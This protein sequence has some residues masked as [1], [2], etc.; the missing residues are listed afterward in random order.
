MDGEKT[1]SKRESNESCR[2][3]TWWLRRK[4]SNWYEG[5]KN[6]LGK[7]CTRK[8]NKKQKKDYREMD[9]QNKKRK[10]YDVITWEIPRCKNIIYLEIVL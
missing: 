9:S 10:T 1:N 5:S 6:S 8:E 7:S 4:S 2:S 3:S